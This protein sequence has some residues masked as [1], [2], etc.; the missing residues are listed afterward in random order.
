MKINKSYQSPNFDPKPIPVEFIV[1]HYTACSLETTLEI[2]GDKS[3]K[4]S[5]QL[6]LAEDGEVFEMVKCWDNTVERAWHAGVSYYNDGN[7]NWEGF[8]DFSIGIEVVNLNGNIFDFSEAQ[9][10][11]LIEIIT[12]FKSKHKT[13]EDPERIIGHEQIAKQRGK[14]DPGWKFDWER[15]YTSCY[16]GMKQPVREP[17]L[18]AQIQE[19]GDKFVKN[20][21]QDKSA[22]AKFWQDL[23][24]TME[25]TSKIANKEETKV[26]K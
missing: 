6:V 1:V 18:P 16:P 24:S 23:N 8:N 10:L 13:L 11:S 9:Y 22:Q 25:E 5:S 21:P 3:R 4:V 26:E 17:N 15:V 14:V 19:T 20:M 12:Y 7:R 2:F